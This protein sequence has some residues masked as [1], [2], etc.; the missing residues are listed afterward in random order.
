MIELMP[1][2][3]VSDYEMVAYLHMRELLCIRDL[4]VLERGK[5][6]ACSVHRRDSIRQFKKPVPQLD[7]TGEKMELVD[8]DCGLYGS[9]L[10]VRIGPYF[11]SDHPK[12][13]EISTNLLWEVFERPHVQTLSDMDKQRMDEITETLEWIESICC[14]KYFDGQVSYLSKVLIRDQALIAAETGTGKTLMA[15]S[16]YMVKGA[17][18][19]LIVCPKGVASS[20]GSE[21]GQWFSELQKFA[22]HIEIYKLF[23]HDDYEEIKL[24]NDGRLPDGIYVSYYDAFFRNNALECNASSNCTDAVLSKMVGI[25]VENN[26]SF[27]VSTIGEEEKGIRC[28]AKPSLSTL[29]G[30]EFDMVCLDEAHTIKSLNSITTK[31][32]IRLRPKYRFAFT[33]T[34]VPNTASDLFPLMGWLCVDDWYKGGRSNNLW[35]FERDD[36]QVFKDKYMSWERDYTAERI[37]MEKDGRSSKVMKRSPTLSC[38]QELIRQI[39]PT[40]AYITKRECNRDYRPPN[41]INVRVPMGLKQ[42]KLYTH[43][44]NLKNVVKTLKGSVIEHPM[45]RYTS[46]IEWLRAICADPQ[47]ASEKAIGNA[48]VPTFNPKLITVMEITMDCIRRGEQVVIVNSRMGLTNTIHSM[49]ASVGVS[50]SRID[51]TTKNTAEESMRFKEGDTDVCLMGIRCAVGHSYSN[52]RNLIIASLE[53][54]AGPFEQA[55]GRVDRLTSNSSDIY[56]ILHENTIEEVIYNTVVKKQSASDTLLKCKETDTDIRV[57]P[58]LIKNIRGWDINK[59][60]TVCE[61][62]CAQRW[63]KIVSAWDRGGCSRNSFRKHMVIS[64]N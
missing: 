51:S 24:H 45:V 23:D 6:Y 10:V 20:Q 35:P 9:D 15:I 29:I 59:Q 41:I 21:L 22:P 47:A 7:S 50:V 8:H 13:D 4:G 54:S 48:V 37:A 17:N 2:T 57:S 5:R 49:L 40:V 33:A 58:D 3:P 16:A 36:L 32:A 11:F 38:P 46:Q 26:Y 63:S 39:K 52:C 44:T 53:Y 12:N 28:I 34:P 62:I 43:F 61:S 30:D 18:R 25:P 1:L 64:A 27:L 19:C 60:R 31:T 56:C 42:S 55:K 14:F